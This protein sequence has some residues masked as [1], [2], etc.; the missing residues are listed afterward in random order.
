MTLYEFNALPEDA[1]DAYFTENG[2]YLA[3]RYTSTHSI[4]LYAVDSFFV[5]A[6]YEPMT[7]Y[8]QHLRSFSSVAQ[9]DTYL[10]MIRL[11]LP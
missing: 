9:L 11:G 8:L 1:Q 10:N 2:R 4:N 7:N 6:W 3:R 5:E